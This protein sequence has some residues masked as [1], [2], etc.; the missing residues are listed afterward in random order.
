MTDEMKRIIEICLS[1]KSKSPIEVLRRL[2]AEDFCPMHGPIHHVLVGSSLLTAYKNA[3][4]KVDLPGALAEIQTRAVKV[5]G[6]AC[7]NWG[8]CGAAIST[9]MFL[10]IVTGNNPLAVENW[11]LANRMTA[12]ALN[13]IGEV[14][15]QGAAKEILTSP[16][17]RRLISSGTILGWR[18]SK[19]SSNAP[20]A[21]STNSASASVVRFCHKKRTPASDELG[22]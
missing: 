19:M 14:A 11:G 20:T 7:G 6:G 13:A 17:S 1:E 15:A 9:G 12:S 22:P 4:G 2:M 18:W 5:P 21:P 8:A 16:L 3:G 10:S